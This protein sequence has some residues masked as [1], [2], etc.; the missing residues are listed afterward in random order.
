[1]VGTRPE[2][3]ATAAG[4]SERRD[5]TAAGVDLS[6]LAAPGDPVGRHPLRLLRFERRWLVRVFE[7]LLP[8]GADP[9]LPVGAADVPMGRFVD[10]LAA[11]AP[12][13][14]LCGLRA[15]LWLLMLAPPFVL[16]RPRSFL[17]LAPDD[18]LALL[19]RLRQSRVY[20]VRELALLFKIVACLGFCGLGPVQRRL[21][22]HPTDT[23]APGWG[24]RPS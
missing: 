2:T 15:G 19:E 13:A 3:T 16:R 6:S 23:T 20:L 12:L 24:A 1:M 18:R 4:A 8:S 22:I 9:R 7:T 11:R 10:D 14:F 21:G 17:G 5:G